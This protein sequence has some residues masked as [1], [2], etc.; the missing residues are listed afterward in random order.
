MNIIDPD[1]KRIEDRVQSMGI[2]DDFNR[3]NLE[4]QMVCA[5]Y[6]ELKRKVEK[7]QKEKLQ[8]LNNKLK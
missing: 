7:L 3:V 8:L 5:E 6:L 2:E 1:L 4:L